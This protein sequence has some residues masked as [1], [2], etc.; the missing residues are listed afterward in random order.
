MNGVIV[1]ILFDI[2]LFFHLFRKAEKVGISINNAIPYLSIYLDN[3]SL[4]GTDKYLKIISELFKDDTEKFENISMFL[5]P[6]LVNE[7][8]QSTFL[9]LLNSYFMQYLPITFGSSPNT[10]KSYKYTYKL[11]FRSFLIKE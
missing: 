7:E 3:D 8:N 9:T 6:E 1:C 10:I 2:A 5:F 11:L 4:N